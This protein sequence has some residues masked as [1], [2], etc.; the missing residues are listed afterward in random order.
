MNTMFHEE[1]LSPINAEISRQ[2]DR[3]VS[4]LV[5]SYCSSLVAVVRAI[6]AEYGEKGKE[7]ARQGYLSELK[8]RAREAERKG[9]KG[10]VQAFCA[11]LEKTCMNTH[12]WQRVID[13]QN[14]VAYHFTRCMWAEEFRRLGAPDIG[15]WLCDTDEPAAKAA[16]LKF[17]R[18][19]TIVEGDEICDHIFYV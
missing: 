10:D 1:I 4:Q 8:E 17:E 13:E 7:V 16:N 14:K 9:G 5:R 12:E 18:T 15:K 6:E 19:R 3:T 11:E 2:F